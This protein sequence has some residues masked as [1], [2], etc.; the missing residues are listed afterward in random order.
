M[1]Q[2]MK[3]LLLSLSLFSQIA[4]AKSFLPSSFSA[5]FEESYISHTGKEKKNFGKIDYQYPGKIRFE[6]TSPDP[7]VFVSNPKQSWYYVPP[8]VE[9]EPGQVTI[10]K[11]SNLPLTKFLDSIKDGIEGSKL[12]THK[13]Q[14]Q[15]LQLDFKDGQT[16]IPLKQAILHGKKDPKTIDSMSD[17][18]KLTL[19]HTDGKKVSLRFLELKENVKFQDGHFVF[20]VPAKT[21]ITQ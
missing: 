16:E 1:D 20:K 10:Q 14:G 19:V 13:Y 2:I 6:Y 18:E 17:F 9:G 15:E 21:K 3:L 7:S 4:T 12:F 8:F 11:S 5:N